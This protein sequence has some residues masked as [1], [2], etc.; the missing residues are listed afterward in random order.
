MYWYA[1][2][3][4]DVL[5][6]R[7][8]KP[9][10]PGEGSW[11]KGLF[12]PLPSTV[13]Q[14]LRSLLP[15]YEDTEEEKIKKKRGRERDLD[16]VGPFLM[17]EKWQLKGEKWE[18]EDVLWLP[19]PKDL[20]GVR[21][22]PSEELEKVEHTDE[23]E[24]NWQYTDRLQPAP[25]DGGWQHFRFSKEKLRSPVAP[26]LGKDKRICRPMP[27]IAASALS[28]YLEGETLKNPQEFHKDPWNL[29][30]L[31]HIHMQ[32]EVRLVREQEGYFTE[33]AIRLEPGWRLVAA[34]SKKLEIGEKTTVRLG[35]EGHGALVYPLAPDSAVVR[36]WQQLQE[37]EEPQES[38][39]VAYVLTPGL[40]VSQEE[41]LLYGAYPRHWQDHLATCITDRALLWGGVSK[42]KRKNSDTGQQDE[43]AEFAL[44]PQR[45]FAPPGTVYIFKEPPEP[46]EADAPNWPE[47]FQKLNQGKIVWPENKPPLLLPQG[48]R[49]WHETFEKLNYG[50]LLWGKNRV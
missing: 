3:P 50:K 44:L 46:P 23:A 49:K 9:F 24:D 43:N 27:W 41:P 31:P 40:A 21:I 16:F 32:S 34:I 12:P 11:A 1:I 10:S 19:T 25:E 26:E 20:L 8:A 22:V 38:S 37:F 30:I 47:S 5:L 4:I 2:E 29:Q 7:E 18:R 36:Q 15:Q 17:Q 13:F 35:G 45:A 48:E 6:F 39:R 33:V 14:A 42:V 28:Q